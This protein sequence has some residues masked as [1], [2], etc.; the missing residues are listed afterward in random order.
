MPTMTGSV[1]SAKP[2][3]AADEAAARESGGK[4]ENRVRLADV[5]AQAGVSTATVSKV[6]NGSAHVAPETRERIEALLAEHRYLRRRARP[7]KPSGLID[8]V[9][10]E[11]DSP[12]S[13]EIVRGVE[14]VTHAAKMGLVVTAAHGRSSD[15]RV[16]LDAMAKRASDGVILAV[17]ALSPAQRRQLDELAVPM[18]MV[19]PVGLP[20]P[21]IPAVGATNW[22]GGMAATQHLIDLGHQRIAM[23]A[24]PRD[25]MCSRARVDGYRAALEAAGLT[26]DP[27]LLHHGDFRHASGFTLGGKLLDLPEPPTAIFAASDLQA[28]GVYEAARRRGL[29]VGEDLSVVGFD[30]LPLAEYASPPL[31][32]VRQ[33]LAE[34]AG[35]AARCLV[36]GIEAVMPGTT[37]VELATALVVRDS[38]APPS[39]KG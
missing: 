37:R 2:D 24:G 3:A 19:D 11:L 13:T 26:A 18:V 16:W 5:A 36:Q 31:T 32:T 39:H 29:R 17:T 25:I 33:P 22:A 34:M 20:E 27:K 23:I 8:L 21:G 10:N 7:D 4:P 30:D 14:E 1:N 9:I 12:W 38:T 6:L 35:M 28:W 15:T